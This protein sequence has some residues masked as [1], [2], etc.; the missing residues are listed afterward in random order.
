MWNSLLVDSYRNVLILLTF[1]L[2][3]CKVEFVLIIIFNMFL[4]PIYFFVNNLS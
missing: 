3:F 2:M 1:I 4:W